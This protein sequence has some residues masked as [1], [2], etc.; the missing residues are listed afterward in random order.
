MNCFKKY[1]ENR[2]RFVCVECDQNFTIGIWK[3]LWTPHMDMWRYRY[4]K[5][6]YCGAHHWLKAEKTIK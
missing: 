1:Y 5:C 6:P 3:W 2:R 4:V